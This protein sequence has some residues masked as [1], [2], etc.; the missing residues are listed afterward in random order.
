MSTVDV[1]VLRALRERTGKTD[2]L[3]GLYV[4]V[5]P[6]KVDSPAT[7]PHCSKS[8]RRYQELMARHIAAQPSIEPDDSALLSILENGLD[9]VGELVKARKV[10]D[11][12]AR[13]NGLTYQQITTRGHLR[14]LV[15][16]RREA[17]FIANWLECSYFVTAAALGYRNHTSVL[18]LLGRKNRRSRSK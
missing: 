17:A 7:V 9:G 3:R 10:V 14:S 16:L 18:H 6:K 8:S 11:A 15:E 2:P 13:A 1:S 5:K 12:V 4:S